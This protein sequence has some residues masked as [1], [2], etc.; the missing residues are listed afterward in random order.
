MDKNYIANIE[1][2]LNKRTESSYE[3]FIKANR[4][5]TFIVPSYEI[6]DGYEFIFVKN[7]ANHNYI[8]VFTDE[9]EFNLGC[10]PIVPEGIKAVPLE[11]TIEVLDKYTE[12]K[13]VCLGIIIDIAS[14]SITLNWDWL[15]RIISNSPYDIK[16]SEIAIMDI[17]D[18]SEML[19]GLLK[20]VL[21]DYGNQN[22][23]IESIFVVGLI[24]NFSRSRF[25]VLMNI[26]DKKSKLDFVKLKQNI[27]AINK[28]PMT[29]AVNDGSLELFN[30]AKNTFT[31]VYKKCIS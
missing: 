28:V 2:F 1:N 5:K 20:N 27:E 19:P 21:I 7:N 29:I 8:P 23:C 9:M 17:A 11:L 31:A 4:T 30:T 10:K 16:L 15:N 26:A 6:E 13:K 3:S 24:D 14:K 12:L 25:L 18:M 22:L